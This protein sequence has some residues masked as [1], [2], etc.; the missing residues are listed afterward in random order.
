MPTESSRGR[1]RVPVRGAATP[2]GSTAGASSVDRAALDEYLQALRDT[3]ARLLR[4]TD[5]E[6]DPKL[7]AAMDDAVMEQYHAVLMNLFPRRIS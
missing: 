2:E 1:Q 6:A 3:G 4:Q 7:S 5:H